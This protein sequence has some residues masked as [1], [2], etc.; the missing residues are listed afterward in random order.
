MRSRR[1][2]WT[3][4]AGSTCCSKAASRRRR[5]RCATARSART[6]PWRSACAGCARTETRSAPGSRSSS[7]P[8]GQRRRG[9][10]PVRDTSAS[11]PSG[12]TSGWARHSARGATIRWP[13]GAV[14]TLDDLEAEHLYEVVEGSGVASKRPFAPR[15]WPRGEAALE[16][17]NEE[18]VR[19]DLAARP[20][21]AAGKNVPVRG[22]SV[23][24]PASGRHRPRPFPGKPSISGRRSRRSRKRRPGTPCSGAIFSI[25]GSGCRCP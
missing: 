18:T 21:A 10:T 24:P 22:S 9:C 12:C 25:T 16:A 14:E 8:A 19:A 4:T 17:V 1:R 23:S 5:A 2:I 13:S 15:P 11:T 6:A 7:P 20:V 3:A